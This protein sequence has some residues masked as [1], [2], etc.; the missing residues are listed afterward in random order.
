MCSEILGLIAGSAVIQCNVPGKETDWSRSFNRF[1]PPDVECQ[2]TTPICPS[3]NIISEKRFQFIR[4]LSGK[5]V[6]ICPSPYTFAGVEVGIFVKVS[7]SLGLTCAT[8]NI[9][10][11]DAAFEKIGDVDFKLK[12]P[13][14]KFVQQVDFTV[15]TRTGPTVVHSLKCTAHSEDSA[16]TFKE[17]L[18]RSP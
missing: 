10:D 2:T 3:D 8:P 9:L 12:C 4:L 15:E 6:I 11:P 18:R 16:A 17:T 1:A 13:N 14:G 7:G 5:F